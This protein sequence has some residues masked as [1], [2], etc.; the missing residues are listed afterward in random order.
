MSRS[1]RVAGITRAWGEPLST[2]QILAHEFRYVKGGGFNCSMASRVGADLPG[3]TAA[4][5]WA[6]AQRRGRDCTKG[7]GHTRTTSCI[8]RRTSRRP[9]KSNAMPH[10]MTAAGDAHGR[11]AGLHDQARVPSAFS[12]AFRFRR[13]GRRRSIDRQPA[14]A[15]VA[16][17]QVE[18][19]RRWRAGR[20]RTDLARRRRSAGRASMISASSLVVTLN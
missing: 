1:W 18:G 9:Q 15:G 11:K 8:S 12:Q 13:G 14:N 17:A 16:P 20:G 19:R 10:V 6:P 4:E 5:R 7:T 3:L 2:K